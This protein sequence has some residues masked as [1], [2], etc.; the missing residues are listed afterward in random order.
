MH[1]LFTSQLKLLAS[2]QIL[3]KLSVQTDMLDSHLH[4]TLV[5]ID[6]QGVTCA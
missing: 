5:I 2:H 4:A 6:R 1:Y 3:N